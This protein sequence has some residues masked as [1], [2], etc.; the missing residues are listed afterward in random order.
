MLKNYFI[1]AI[2]ALRKNKVY[3][4]I[5]TLGMGIAMACCITAYL[6]IA[7]NIEFDDY[8]NDRHVENTVKVMHHY[9]TATES[10]EQE[11]VCPTALAPAAVKEISGI[12]DFTRYGHQSGVVSM[13]ENAFEESIRF[14][15]V[16]FFKMFDLDLLK[17]SPKNFEDRQSIFLSEAMA[18]KYFAHEDPIGKTLSVDFFG[19]RYDVVVGGV[20]QTLPLNSSFQID[21]LMRMEIYLDVFDLADDWGM[22][23]PVSVLFKISDIS[24]RATIAKQM[25][26]YLSLENQKEKEFKT[27]GYELLPFRQP[28]FK[29]E[30]GST[31]LRLPIPGIAL[32]IFAT[33]AS[34]ILLIACFNLTNT[35]LV[36]A[37]KRLKEIGVRK[38]V[39]SSQSQI[40]RQFLLESVLTISLAI[41]AG[42]LLAQI[43]VPQFAIMWQ[44]Q[45]GLQQLN[46]TN[47]VIALM[48][49]LFCA[50]ILAGIYPALVNSKVSPILLLKGSQ[51]TQGSRPLMRTLLV[52]QFTLS[53]M[54]FIAGI[55]FTRNAAYQQNLYLGYDKDM[56]I[57]VTVQG[58]QIYERLKNSIEQNPK[59]ESIAGTSN[60]I[61]P[62]SARKKIIKID[63][64]AFE[65]SVYEI[66][67]NYFKTMG[68][69]LVAGREFAAGNEADYGAAVVDENF[70]SN[71]HLAEPIGI[72][73]LYNSKFYQV[74]GVVKNLLSGLKQ[75]ND[76][77]HLYTLSEPKNYSA[78]VV[79]TNPSDRQQVQSFI[80]KEW[81]KNFP[82]KP[83]QSALQEDIV[84]EEAG[85]YNKNLT[86]ILLFLTVMGCILSISG[87]YAL[88]S[89]NVQRRTKEI[90]VRKV[91]GASVMSI[92]RL[93]N[94]E[95]AVILG[96][97]VVLGGTGGYILTDTLLASLFAQHI[98]V[99]VATALLCGLVIFL[100]GISAASGTI[101]RSAVAN[102]VDSLRAE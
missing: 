72:R 87:V 42:I 73:V 37:G 18:T 84:Y 61:S 97:A 12:E 16:S 75:R 52:V 101:F 54:V 78:L 3:V 43:M 39:G 30:V 33:L 59:I 83:F 57:K 38:V 31:N 27:I 13:G 85:G 93:L 46:G 24:H 76:S 48:I 67:V 86:Q 36:F 74:V 35:T 80:E 63:T 88:S 60:H 40:T 64:A 71:H 70:A 62:Y 92:I 8:F 29:S 79:R 19:K 53:V 7:Y 98:K 14:A 51:Y 45:Y 89:L 102:P 56:I 77:E 23:Q 25:N 6:L 32:I 99:G 91:L 47:L 65:T 20:L 34:I 49:L 15:D 9:Q 44:L 66:G 100:I 41:A 69:P 94:R 17:G 4:L 50:A 5:N 58:E 11:L 81:K 90:G 1:V 28:V 96:L 21:A 95:F 55:V 22:N 68:L 10:N 26:K 82:G 2:R